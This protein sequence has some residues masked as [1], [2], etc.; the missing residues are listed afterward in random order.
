MLLSNL[1]IENLIIFISESTEDK[2]LIIGLG[3]G[4]PA[5]VIVI[6][7]AVIFALYYF[8]GTASPG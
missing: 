1:I 2:S 8:K 5:A 6:A 7:I 4:L 3:I